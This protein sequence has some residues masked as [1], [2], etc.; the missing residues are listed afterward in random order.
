MNAK[1]DKENHIKAQHDQIVE[2]SVIL[3]C[4]YSN[5]QKDTLN[6]RGAY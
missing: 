3:K 6:Y 4:F 1:Q 5:W 2:K